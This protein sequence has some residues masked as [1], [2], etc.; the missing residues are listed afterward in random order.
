MQRCIF[1]SHL[2]WN[3]LHI[4]L[5]RSPSSL[6]R[7]HPAC[8]KPLCTR[9]LCPPRGSSC[10]LTS[11]TQFFSSSVGDI[12]ESTAALRR[13][14]P[15]RIPTFLE[16]SCPDRKIRPQPLGF[17]PSFPIHFPW[18]LR[19]VTV[20]T[21]FG[22]ASRLEADLRKFLWLHPVTTWLIPYLC[23]HT[24]DHC[25]P[26]L[27]VTSGHLVHLLDHHTNA[28]LNLAFLFSPLYRLQILLN[29]SCNNFAFYSP[30]IC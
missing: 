29:K 17:M 28:F 20:I 26:G 21:F 1:Q 3:S 22:A 2:N 11:L 5:G 10:L 27:E 12:P 6:W 23:L 13:W 25:H 16:H 19:A 4:P 30:R 15:S 14:N 9:L 8:S 7:A 18:C 24:W